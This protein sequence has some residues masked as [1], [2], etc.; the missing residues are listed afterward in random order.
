MGLGNRYAL[1]PEHKM[2]A[3]GTQSCE[4]V[5]STPICDHIVSHGVSDLHMFFGDSTK[6]AAQ[7][8]L[9]ESKDQNLRKPR[10]DTIGQGKIAQFGC[11]QP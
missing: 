9:S 11:H 3:K 4:T 10:R 6:G 2:Q 1:S 5:P 8:Q 7:R